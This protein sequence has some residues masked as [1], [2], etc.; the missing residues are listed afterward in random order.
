M[1]EPDEEWTRRIH[2][3]LRAGDPTAT[4]ELAEA[5]GNV[6]FRRLRSRY[7]R[8]DADMVADAAWDA[9]LAYMRRPDAFDPSRRSLL[10]YLQMAAEGDLRNAMAKNRRRREDPLPDVELAD[11]RGKREMEQLEAS[12]DAARLQE[13][14]RRRFPDPRDLAA[15]ALLLEDER[16]T[17]AFTEVWGLGSLPVEEQRQEVKRGKDR[18]KKALLRLGEEIRGRKV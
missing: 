5:L 13:E 10:G 12:M 14:L 18:L 9:L 16:S 15:V 3:R 2:G 8:V 1:T 4:A 6:L 7:A 11:S 17:S